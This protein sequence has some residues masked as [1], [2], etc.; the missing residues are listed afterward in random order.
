M[1]R[2]I[3]AKLEKCGIRELVCFSVDCDSY[4]NLLEIPRIP[5]NS[6]NGKSYDHKWIWDNYVK[7]NWQYK[8]YNA[9]EYDYY[10]R[11]RIEV[12]RKNTVIYLSHCIRKSNIVKEIETAFGL[13]EYNGLRKSPETKIP[14]NEYKC[15]ADR[16]L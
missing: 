16:F 5:L 15:Y 13:T 2:I 7:H 3:A 11:G 10:P 9:K 8:P 4:G 6:A 1:S 14:P 12:S